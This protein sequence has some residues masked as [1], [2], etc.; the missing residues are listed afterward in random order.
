M[1]DVDP[2]LFA[3]AP[4]LFPSQAL[5]PEG[6][7]SLLRR[8]DSDQED[9]ELQNVLRLATLSE[10][11]YSEFEEMR[12]SSPSRKVGER[13]IAHLTTDFNSLQIVVPHSMKSNVYSGPVDLWFRL[14]LNIQ[15]MLCR[16]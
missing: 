3:L 16:C 13:A 11:S 4:G 5:P 14:T 8:S 12:T 9:R 6:H 1:N 10:G 2:S 15:R 7:G